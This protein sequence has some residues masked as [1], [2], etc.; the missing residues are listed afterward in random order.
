MRHILNFLLIVI[1]SACFTAIYYYLYDQPI[2]G[3]DDANIYFVYVKNFVNGHGFVYN[4]GSE[5]VEGFTSLLWVL[6][7]SPLYWLGSPFEL[8]V[9]LLNVLLLS[10]I[11][12][13]TLRLIQYINNTPAFFSP[14]ACLVLSFLFLIPGFVEWMTLSLME[15]A[16]WC[17]LLVS[18]V[19]AAVKFL[20]EEQRRHLIWLSVYVGLLVLTRPE[21]MLWGLVFGVGIALLSGFGLPRRNAWWSP[22]GLYLLGAYLFVLGTLIVIRYSYFGYLL[23]NTYYAKVSSDKV[24]NLIHGARYIGF[25][26]YQT[27]LLWLFVFG[28]LVSLTILLSHWW[29]ERLPLHTLPKFMKLQ[30]AF[31]LVCILSVALAVYVGGDH[32]AMLRFFQAFI[33]IYFLAL[34]NFPFWK[35]FFV[36]RYEGTLPVSV[37]SGYLVLLLLLPLLYFS[38]QS[39]LHLL[40]E[41][42]SPLFPEFRLASM[43]RQEGKLLTE[44]F[45]QLPEFPTVGVSAAGGFAY[46]YRGATIDLMG[47]NNTEMAH[48]SDVKVG[49]KNHAAFY[50]PTFFS[51][52]PAV[53]HGYT[54]GS[55]VVSAFYTEENDTMPLDENAYDFEERFV[56]RLYKGLF[57]EAR[58]QEEYLPVVISH[59]AVQNIV[60]QTYIHHSFA[61]QLARHGYET[62]ILRRQPEPGP[63]LLQLSA[64]P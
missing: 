32:F 49:L 27:P 7:I 23:P 8:S 29:R 15:N 64:L 5:R 47:L 2:V 60:Y 16:L 14:A 4:V 59:P 54:H 63:S 45:S 51:L 40:S 58:F 10:G 52:Q 22:S 31:S 61:D 38:T 21:S 56:F 25:S 57:Y 24:H 1:L 42:R 55:K 11:V 50:I 28:S 36:F 35:H 30:L 33:P 39:P 53:F 18:T 20:R 13:R 44:L 9:L 17:F 37:R 6:L 62:R 34:L 48:A 43:G 26:L 41:E 3:I 12:Y 46:T 19:G